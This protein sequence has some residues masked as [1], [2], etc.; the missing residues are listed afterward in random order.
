MVLNERESTKK[1]LFDMSENDENEM[2]V[3]G[4]Y[5]FNIIEVVRTSRDC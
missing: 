3:K 5:I 2:K 4:I 1:E